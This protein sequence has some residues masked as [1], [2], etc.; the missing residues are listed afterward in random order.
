[1]FKLSFQDYYIVRKYKDGKICRYKVTGEEN[2]KQELH[3]EAASM[4]NSIRIKSV[5]L[6]N[7]KSTI[8]YSFINKT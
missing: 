6:Q 4:L 5:Q 3:N 8:L 1:V 2:A 7:Y